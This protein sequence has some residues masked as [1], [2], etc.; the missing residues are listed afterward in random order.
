MENI[1]LPQE[2]YYRS[3]PV[4]EFDVNQTLYNTIF[5]QNKGNMYVDA[6]GFLGYSCTYA[7]LKH[8]VD[9]LADAYSKA[10]VKE[11]DSVAIATISMPIAQENLLALSKLGAISKWID[12]RC[13][14]ND[15]ISKINESSCKIAVIFDGITPMIEE[16]LDETDIQQVIVAS[17]K[18]YLNPIIKVLANLKDKKEGK[19]II[20]PDDKRFI[21]YNDFM[22]TGSKNSIIQPVKFE[23]ERPSITNGYIRM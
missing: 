7:D 9:R 6:I 14:K 22:K 19:Q 8:N 3:K 2:K 20:I 4:R 15:L 12:L 17:P 23:K 5:E 10:G 16:I 21:K 18:D 11:G 13:K 1:Q